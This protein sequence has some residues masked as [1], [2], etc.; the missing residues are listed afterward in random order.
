M[1]LPLVERERLLGGNWRIR[2]TA[3]LY[4]KRHWCQVVDAVPAGVRFG[5][6]WDLAAT[7]KTE[8][9]DPDWTESIKLGRDPAT[10]LYYLTDWTRLRASPMKVEEAIRNTASADGSSVE[11]GIPQDPAQAGKAQAEYLIRQLSGY[12]ARA[13]IER[14]EK[15]L[16]FGPFSAQCEAGNV[17]ILRAAWNTDLFDNLEAFPEAAHD[18]TADA[19]SGAFNML[20]SGTSAVTALRL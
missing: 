18:D 5:R 19:C 2:P 4:F 10:K 3:G 17:K 8:I 9:N 14:G 16:R 13:R 7:E 15:P 11:I 20:Q 6:Y 1:A 12:T